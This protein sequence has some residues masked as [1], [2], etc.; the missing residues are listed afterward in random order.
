[1]WSNLTYSSKI[2]RAEK[3]LKEGVHVAS[4][5]LILQSNESCLFLGVVAENGKSKPQS[6]EREEARALD[7][8]VPQ[9]A[10][11]VFQDTDKD[12][13]VCCLI[14]DRR[15]R[16]AVLYAEQLAELAES[17]KAPVAFLDN[18]GHLRQCIGHS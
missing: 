10:S 7:K 13:D 5:P 17:R 4:R 18:N 2:T 9:D 1:M 15:T 12:A 6:G 14:L 3:G 16:V 11:R 8:V